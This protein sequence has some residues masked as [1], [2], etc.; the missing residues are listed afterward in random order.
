MSNRSASNSHND[1]WLRA[2]QPATEPEPK[3]AH[4]P[5]PVI[6]LGLVATLAWLSFIV[7]LVLQ[8]VGWLFN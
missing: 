2:V 6:G 8:L 5:L 4:W 3:P 1:V 7:W